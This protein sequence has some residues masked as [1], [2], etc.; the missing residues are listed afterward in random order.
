MKRRVLLLAISFGSLFSVD[1][2]IEADEKPTKL[3]RIAEIEVEAAQLGAYKAELRREIDASIR[4]EPGV[5]ALYA[6]AVK[7]R[8][9]QIRLFEI[10][11]GEKAYQ[12][13]LQ[14]A[15][16]QKYK[17]ATA[18]MVKSLTLIETDPVDL[19]TR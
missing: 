14:S 3:V 4:L 5:L 1:S 18:G 16:F 2:V 10:Y 6:V 7:N 8:P 12:A 9:N 19:G 15:H 11:A 13:H 17:A